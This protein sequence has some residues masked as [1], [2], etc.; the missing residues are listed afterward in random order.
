MAFCT[1]VGK[2]PSI[3]ENSKSET[4]YYKTFSG[5]IKYHRYYYTISS[6]PDNTAQEL[7]RHINKLQNVSIQIVKKDMTHHLYNIHNVK[8]RLNHVF[9]VS[10]VCD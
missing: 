4:F 9:F 8:T 6:S 10:F 1:L 7:F 3:E 2:K 5:S